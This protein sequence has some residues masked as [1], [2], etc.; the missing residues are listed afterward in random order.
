M[1]RRVCTIVIEEKRRNNR[2]QEL[3][4][5]LLRQRYPSNLVDTAI[6]KAKSIPVADLRISSRTRNQDKIENQIP[7][8]VTHNPRNVNM[9][10]FVKDCFL[11][12]QQSEKFQKPH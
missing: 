5:F 2:L 12:L 7:L 10:S 8:V 6:H 3:K 9:Y 11:I 1:A 4:S